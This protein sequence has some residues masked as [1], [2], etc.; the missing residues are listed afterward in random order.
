MTGSGPNAP[1]IGGEELSVAVDGGSFDWTDDMPNHAVI[2]SLHDRQRVVPRSGLK[3]NLARKHL[4]YLNEPV[5]VVVLDIGSF[6]ALRI[7][8]EIPVPDYNWIELSIAVQIGCSNHRLD[9]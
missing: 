8:H 2:P 5:E 9:V 4:E 6:Y 7:N 1:L 3:L